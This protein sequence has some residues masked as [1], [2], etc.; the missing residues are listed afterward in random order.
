MRWGAADRRH[1]RF[2]N[3]RESRIAAP[4]FPQYLIRA[5]GNASLS[6][7]RISAGPSHRAPKS[8]RPIGRDSDHVCRIRLLLR[9]SLAVV[10][11]GAVARGDDCG[12]ALCTPQKLPV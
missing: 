4:V 1:L 7:I 12:D 3:L 9:G 6:D 8:S 2:N 10:A 5:S 11:E